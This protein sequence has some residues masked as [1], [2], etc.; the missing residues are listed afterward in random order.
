MS[1]ERLARR[2]MDPIISEINLQNDSQVDDA[3][4]MA[5]L[6]Q[7]LNEPLD[8]VALEEDLRKIYGIGEFSSVEFDLH[9]RGETSVLELRAV[10]SRTGNRFWRF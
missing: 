10:E 5:Q 1:A 4:I 3:V 2:S 9:D 6:S 8:K 7:A